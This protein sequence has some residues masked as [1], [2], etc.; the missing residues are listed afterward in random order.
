MSQLLTELTGLMGSGLLAG[1]LTGTCAELVATED[2]L[3]RRFVRDYPRSLDRELRF[4]HLRGTGSAI[5]AGQAALTGAV[6]AATLLT[7]LWLCLTL[8]PV[9]IL[10][11]HYW[12][13]RR[14]ARRVSAVDQQVATFLLALANALRA[15]ASIGESLAVTARLMPAPMNE[16]LQIT[17]RE[18]DLGAPLD[19]AL[20]QMSERI[21][22]RTVRGA[23][24]TLRVARRTG[25]DLSQTLETSAAS[26][27]EMSRLEGVLRSKTAEGRSQAMLIALLPLPFVGVLQWL[28]PELIEPL[29]ETG[30]GHLIV[31]A[32][33]GLWLSA[34]LLARKILAVEM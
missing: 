3:L 25:G 10:L 6:F 26:L 29:G 33:T 31:A 12:L 13:Q 15:S 21:G 17:L 7:G 18:Y 2:G 19:Q 30:T 16:E 14:R 1:G 11:P 5:F 24:G 8:V 20:L 27:R 23:L 28:S 9:V 34:V 4:L 22:S 32:A